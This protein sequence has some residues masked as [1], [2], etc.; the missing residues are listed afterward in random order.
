MRIAFDHVPDSRRRRGND[1]VVGRP[2][3]QGITS[4]QGQAMN[5]ASDKWSRPRA[6]VVALLALVPVVGAR[7]APRIPSADTV[8]GPLPPED[9][10]E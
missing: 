3:D 2:E 7:V 5:E 10:A 8:S 9:G 6:C 4:G 1:R